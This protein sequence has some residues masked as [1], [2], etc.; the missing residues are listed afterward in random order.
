L[1]LFADDTT[2]IASHKDIHE[3][4]D[5][6]NTEMQKISNWLIINKLALNISKTKYII[7]RTRGKQIPNNIHPVEINQNEIGTIEHE[8]KITPIDRVWNG[9]NNIENRSFKL[10]GVYLD[11]YLSFD[12]NTDVLCAKLTRANYCMKRASNKISL[13]SLRCL[14]FAMFHSHLNYCINIA[15]CTSQ[16]NIS[17]ISKLQK[18]AIRIINKARVNEH[19]APLFKTSMILPYEKMIIYNRLMF[20]HAIRYNYAPSSTIDL[21][22]R[23]IERNNDYVF[24]NQADFIVPFPRIDVFKKSPLYILPDTWNKSGYLIFYEN[25]VTFMIALKHELFSNME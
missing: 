8:S 2:A 19:T 22:H 18:K 5:H 6:V 20:M 16:S 7:F 4:I 12:K 17:R 10:L 9:A 21:F 1:F 24:R 11:E 23:T 3:L 15:S 13:K 14:Y 25:N